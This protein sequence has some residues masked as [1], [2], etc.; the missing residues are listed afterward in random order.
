V[1][2]GGEGWGE[3]VVS[4]VYVL[5][6]QRGRGLLL[7]RFSGLYGRRISRCNALTSLLCVEVAVGEIIHRQVGKVV[8]N[9]L[10]CLYVGCVG[11][12]AA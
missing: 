9:L 2:R 11:C 5:M 4:I 10:G 12:G 1:G 3:L 7:H 8:G 6:V